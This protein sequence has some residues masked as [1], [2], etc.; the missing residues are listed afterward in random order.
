MAKRN[1]VLGLLGLA[2]LVVGLLGNFIVSTTA[3]S[4]VG[5]G[6]GCTV[7]SVNPVSSVQ[8]SPS[9]WN[10]NQGQFISAFII[11]G[12]GIVGNLITLTI[13]CTSLCAPSIPQPVQTTFTAGAVSGAWY[14]YTWPATST[15]CTGASFVTGEGC[16]LSGA[17]FT[18][19]WNLPFSGG[20]T[21]SINFYAKIGGITVTVQDFTIAAGPATV[22]VVTG[23]ATTTSA[24]TIAGVNGFTGTVSLAASCTA[25]LTVCTISPVTVSGGSGTA[26]L[27]LGS[28]NTIGTMTA[29]VTG[30]STNL[31]HSALVTVTATSPQG[32]GPDFTLSAPSTNIV[33]NAGTQATLQITVS[34]LFGFVG[35]VSFSVTPSTGLQ[36][37]INPTAISFTSGS[38]SSVIVLTVSASAAGTYTVVVTGVS[39]SLTHSL[40]VY[41]QFG[42]GASTCVSGGTLCVSSGY[43]PLPTFPA[44]TSGCFITCSTINLG[45]VVFTLAQLIAIIGGAVA[46]IAYYPGKRKVG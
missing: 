25:G 13:T 16:Y 42:G 30:T 29:T 44:F 24:I 38:S 19:N 1:S 32:S 37:A 23:A 18:V 7:N 6:T 2:L 5:C 35:G 31:V 46:I 8:S 41:G 17:A 43:S 26:T 22:N 10:T 34:P 45:I 36:A 27:T 9:Q 39:G 3:A 21:Q 20:N 15:S 11:T 4:V 12:Q 40:S 14:N 28:A 33:V